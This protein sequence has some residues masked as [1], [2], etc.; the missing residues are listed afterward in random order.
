MHVIIFF[1]HQNSFATCMH[2]EGLCENKISQ[3]WLQW[4]A[5]LPLAFFW[6]LKTDQRA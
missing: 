3:A 6:A 1:F 4:D 5:P 2:A